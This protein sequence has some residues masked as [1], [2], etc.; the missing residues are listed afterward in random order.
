M[1]R[2]ANGRRFIILKND[3][4]ISSGNDANSRQ[5]FLYTPLFSKNSRFNQEKTV[6]FSSRLIIWEKKG[7]VKSVFQINRQPVTDMT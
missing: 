3:G 5:Y 7:L 1:P 4:K 2:L 6:Q